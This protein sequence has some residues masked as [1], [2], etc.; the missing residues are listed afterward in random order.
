MVE[1]DPVADDG[2]SVRTE[3]WRDARGVVA[4]YHLVAGGGHTWP[5]AGQPFTGG[6]R[7]GTTSPDLDATDAAVQFAIATL[8]ES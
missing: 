3:T 2:T 6:D 4:V 7:F 8:P 5:S 1:S